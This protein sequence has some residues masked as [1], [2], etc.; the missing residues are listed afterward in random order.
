MPQ[1]ERTYFLAGPKQG[2]AT[3]VQIH[4]GCQYNL[5]VEPAWAFGGHLVHLPNSSHSNGNSFC[6]GLY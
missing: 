5:H 3:V 4:P 2:K 6:I 1:K